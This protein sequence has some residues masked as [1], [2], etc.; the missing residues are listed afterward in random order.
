[1]SQ[2]STLNIK[3][4]FLTNTFITLI[5]LG[6]ICPINAMAVDCYGVDL[7]DYGVYAADFMKYKNAPNTDV[8]KIEL[9]SDKALLHLTEYIPG[10]K[11]TKFGIRYVPK[12][13]LEGK[14]VDI[15]VKVLHSTTID[16][17]EISHV[18]EWVTSKKIGK[19]G[20]DGWKFSDESEL[21]HGNWTIQLYHQGMMLT[22]KSFYVY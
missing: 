1:M 6:L 21:I 2:H 19:P 11:G 7:V 5:V 17:R 20:F 16:S 13:D 4:L 14:N 3:S 18:N 15:L 10:K 22:E 9:V 12:G 8:G